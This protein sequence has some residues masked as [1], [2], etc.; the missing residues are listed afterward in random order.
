MRLRREPWSD[1]RHGKTEKCRFHTD[2]L[3]EKLR[4][5]PAIDHTVCL[6]LL[7]VRVVAL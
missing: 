4:G 5:V 7:Q 1:W 2:R 3:C 6:A